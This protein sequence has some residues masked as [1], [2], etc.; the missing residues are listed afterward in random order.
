M[1]TKSSYSDILC[2]GKRRAREMV[3]PAFVGLE[4]VV[5]L[6]GPT[7]GEHITNLRRIKQRGKYFKNITSY[8][9][10]RDVFLQQKPQLDSLGIK[11]V[12]LK[13]G[14]ILQEPNDNNTF[15]ILDF[16]RTIESFESHVRKYTGPAC[17]T[18]ALRGK[19]KFNDGKEAGMYKKHVIKTFFALRNEQI[20]SEVKFGNS[21][22]IVTN[23]NNYLLTTYNDSGTPMIY[24]A[25]LPKNQ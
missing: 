10:D 1:P 22:T 19:N 16:C 4:R 25:C 8:E 6:G 18:F 15:M 12:N 5:T 24:I 23:K 17:F 21:A 3:F 2:P 13:F 11:R 7:I 9:M 14:D 20:T